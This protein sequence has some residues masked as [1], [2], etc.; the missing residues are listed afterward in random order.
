MKQEN[1]PSSANAV[2]N[3]AITRVTMKAFEYTP[4]FQFLEQAVANDCETTQEGFEVLGAMGHRT[5]GGRPPTL[6]L[7]PPKSELSDVETRENKQ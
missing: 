4:E 7:V 6:P 3:D 2:P 5:L 1:Q